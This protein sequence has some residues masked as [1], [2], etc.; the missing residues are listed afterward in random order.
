M[1]AI[2][3]DRRDAGRRLAAALAGFAP[4]RPIVYGLPR[5]GVPVAAEVAAALDA[6]LDIILVRKIGVPGQPE[7]AMGAVVD[8][9]RPEV[10]W[11][12]DIV[13]AFGVLQHVRDEAVAAQLRVID[14]RRG[15]YGL[16]PERP[17]P[18]G[19][20]AIVVDDGLATGATAVVALRALRRMGAARVILAAP[21]GPPETVERLR[22]EADAVVCL[23]R[24]RR[25]AGVG[26]FYEDFGQ[27]DDSEVLVLLAEAAGRT[28]GD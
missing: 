2:F 14:A 28:R 8:G 18:K 4:E 7:L 15:L 24:P 10:F 22:S 1:S 13:A 20:T 26:A 5:G 19:R 12:D 27:T 17:S 25:F 11:N 9:D 21:V 6:P 16:R 23:E 3:I